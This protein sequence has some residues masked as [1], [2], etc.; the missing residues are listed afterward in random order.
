MTTTETKLALTIDSTKQYLVDTSM[1]FFNPEEIGF[2]DYVSFAKDNTGMVCYLDKDTTKRFI[3]KFVWT[4]SVPSVVELTYTAIDMETYQPTKT[5]FL[6]V[7]RGPYDLTVEGKRTSPQL[8]L[9]FDACPFPKYL[10]SSKS[11]MHEE[12]K[13][14]Y[15]KS[16]SIV[17]G[18]PRS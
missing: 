1:W 5:L 10:D 2:K 9:A 11:Q 18:R 3:F 14:F 6:H 13:S 16:Q 15:G 17:M 8:R 4:V 7:F 12:I